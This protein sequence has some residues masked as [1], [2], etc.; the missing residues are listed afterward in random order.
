[1]N[2]FAHYY[3]YNKP[4]N[5]WHNAG[6]LFPDLIRNFTNEQRITSKRELICETSNYKNLCEGIQNH[7]KADDIFHNWAWFKQTNHELALIIREKNLGIT[8]D[9]F[10]AHIFIELAIDH[11]LVIENE[12]L[13]KDLYNDLANCERHGWSDFFRKNQFF[14]EDKWQKGLEQFNTHK[15]IFTYKDTDN[16]VYALNRI[17]ERTVMVKLSNPQNE[18]LAVL[19][20]NFIPEVKSKLKELHTILT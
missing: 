9:W 19:L 16:I 11:V 10:L 14:E 7:F 1:M 4:G 2:F 6:L 20:N 12:T 8:R 13:V 3:Y 5:A 17:Y 18:L 15:Y